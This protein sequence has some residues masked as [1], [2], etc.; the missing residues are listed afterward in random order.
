MPPSE[1]MKTRWRVKASRYTPSWFHAC[2]VSFVDAVDAHEA[3]RLVEAPSMP[4][5]ELRVW[6]VTPATPAM[7]A[8]YVEWLRKCAEW[9]RLAAKAQ[10]PQKGLL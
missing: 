8:Q 9:K 4:D 7:E 10:A 1:P 2:E 5:C 6:A 3:K